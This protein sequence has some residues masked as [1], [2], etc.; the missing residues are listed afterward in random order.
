MTQITKLDEL[1]DTCRTAMQEQL[2][3]ISLEQMGGLGQWQEACVEMRSLLQQSF[4]LLK[5]QTVSQTEMDR[6]KNSLSDLVGLNNQL[7]GAADKQRQKV[8]ERIKRMRIGKSALNGY[9]TRSQTPKPR[10]VSSNG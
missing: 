1:I 7:Y 4:E 5:G 2:A 10:F 3:N 6:L 9:G 8:G